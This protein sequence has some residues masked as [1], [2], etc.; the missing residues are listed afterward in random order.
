MKGSIGTWVGLLVLLAGCSQSQEDPVKDLRR[1]VERPLPPSD[2]KGLAPLPGP[3]KPPEVT[4]RAPERS[5]FSAIPSLQPAQKA[6]EYAGPQPDP[7]RDPDP[8]E[9]FALGALKVVGI[10]LS[11]DRG[12][13]AYV[14][15]PDGVVY[16]VLPG[17]YMGQQYGRVEKIAPNKIVL[18]ELI[19]RGKGR[20]KPKRRTIGF[21]ASS[22][23]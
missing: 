10:L 17:D 21:A 12:R 18:R 9:Q 14:R 23:R 3:V 20:W 1:F 11:P 13:Q 7:E 19:S 16:T 6:T 8:L 5:P 2:E 22:R 15:A 4:F